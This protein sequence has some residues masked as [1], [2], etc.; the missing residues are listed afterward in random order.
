MHPYAKSKYYKSDYNP[1]LHYR[2]EKLKERFELFRKL[3]GLEIEFFTEN[4]QEKEV[5]REYWALKGKVGD[6]GLVW[7]SL[8]GDISDKYSERYGFKKATDVT[9]FVGIRCC[10]YFGY[11]S[12][13]FK[14]RT[15][16]ERAIYTEDKNNLLDQIDLKLIKDRLGEYA[17]LEIEEKNNQISNLGEFNFDQLEL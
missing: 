11:S 6:Y 1:K 13:K 4:K 15:E 3:G 12:K 14:N 16:F 9:Y 5:C 10:A 7:K 2:V 8:V 17:F